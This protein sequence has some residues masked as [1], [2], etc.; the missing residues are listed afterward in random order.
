MTANHGHPIV[1]AC[2]TST[3][4]AS[5]A[6]VEG[7]VMTA[8]TTLL[9]ADSH[10][11]RL[12]QDVSDLLARRGLAAADLDVLV[13][14]LGPGSFTGVRIALSA[15]KGLAY[16]LGRPLVGVCGLDA[17]ARPLTGRGAAVLTAL[18]A[19]KGEVYA[20]LHASDGTRLM[21]PCVSDPDRF[22]SDMAAA[23]PGCPVIGAGEGVLAYR[24]RFEAALG[25]RLKVAD[26]HEHAIRASV[27]ATL[28]LEQVAPGPGVDA[29]EPLYLRRSEA[30]VKLGL[31]A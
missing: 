1:L 20:A 4:V 27:I 14:S 3:R 24:G 6:L 10:S 29:L 9:S 8:E 13:T 15:M 26:A 28:G 12:L 25:G 18:D 19:R 11:E 21:A 17:L 23:A 7:G 16:A 5:V 31:R 30:E 2:D 22:A